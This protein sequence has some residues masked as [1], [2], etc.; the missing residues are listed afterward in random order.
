MVLLW[1]SGGDRTRRR[2][3]GGA[4]LEAARR[5]RGAGAA[6]GKQEVVNRQ[7]EGACPPGCCLTWLSWAGRRGA[8]GTAV[9]G[10][11]SVGWAPAQVRVMTSW[12]AAAPEEREKDGSACAP[13]TWTTQ[14]RRT[15][16]WGHHLTSDPSRAVWRRDVGV[17]RRSRGA[18]QILHRGSDHLQRLA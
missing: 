8:A 5:R 11:A 17:Q 1:G 12:D 13:V 18:G 2:L 9:G 15:H 3:R 4:G 16:L 7:R 6:G 10:A 14:S